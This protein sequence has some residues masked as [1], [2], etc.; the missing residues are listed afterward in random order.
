MPGIPVL[1]WDYSDRL[2]ATARQAAA[3]RGIPETTYYVY[4]A[5]GQRVRK[6]TERAATGG[7]AHSRKSE[8]IYLGTFE[9]YREYAH[10]GT[11]TLERETLH[12]LDDKHRVALVE[13]RTVGTD[14][15]PR[16]LTR[17]QL[18]SHLDS[19]VLELDQHAQVISYEEYYPYGST[20]YQAVRAKT[21]TP[22]RYRYTGK[23]RD[24][25]T[26]LS[27]HGAR[28]YAP[29][30]GRWASCDPIG[31]A[32]SVDVYIYVN[33]N[34]IVA[35][36]STGHNSDKIIDQNDPYGGDLPPGGAPEQAQANLPEVHGT[37]REEAEQRS[38]PEEHAPPQGAAVEFSGASFAEVPPS[39]QADPIGQ[40][41]VRL[42]A[43]QP[44]ENYDSPVAR[45]MAVRG[46]LNLAEIAEAGHGCAFCHIVKEY[47][48]MRDA[49][50][51]I[52]LG[53]Y[54]AVSV[55]LHEINIQFA[56]IPLTVAAEA[57]AAP[58]AEAAALRGIKVYRGTSNTSELQIHAETGQLMSDAARVGY[59]ESGGSVQAARAASETAHAAGIETWGSEAAYAQ[60]H[61]EFSSELSQIGARSMLSVT[62]D[63]AVAKFFA[64]SGG[65]V[66]SAVVDPALLIPQTMKTANESEF[67]ITHMFGAH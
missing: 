14:R 15:G 62:T 16:E 13:T 46:Y 45:Q 61:G 31:L 47:R 3:D 5:A 52:D 9:I 43:D 1:R 65:Q 56:T 44:R 28:Y 48:T 40:S 33:G 38:I 59:E 29:W 23:E 8:R 36:D 12:V 42:R 39:Q 26:G 24:T 63:P 6:V 35:I 17:Y 7:H 25:E 21:E 55:A 4:D 58:A 66:F 54:N 20:S 22:K 41:G 64:G 19:S 51:A 53:H 34:P 27:Y 37:A 67:L 50:A 49:N 30:L 60:A 2:H 57:L 11:A 32:D 18:A 10:D